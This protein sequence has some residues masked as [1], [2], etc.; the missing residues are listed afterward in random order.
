MWSKS[1]VYFVAYLLIWVP[2]GE[3][4][5]LDVDHQTAKERGITFY[6]QYKARTATTFLNTAAESGD[7]EAQ[8]FL[9]E[10]LRQNNRFM[11]PEAQQWLEAAADQGHV[12]SMIRLVRSGSNLC[13]I[14]GTCPQSSRSPEEWY[15]H[16]YDALL[17]LAEQGNAEAMFQMYKLTQDAEWRARAAEAGHSEAQ[18][19]HAAFIEEG[20][21]FFWWPG[22]RQKAVETWFKASAEGGYPLGMMRYA[23]ILADNADEAGYRYWMNKAAK[24]GY[25]RAVYALAALSGHEPEEYGVELDL[26]K[27]YGLLHL[28]LELDGGGSTGSVAKSTLPDIEKK[29]APEQIERALEFAEEW[30][31]AHPPLSYFPHILYELDN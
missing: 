1:V 4:A 6:N 13:S 28:L 27:S 15:Q 19:W 5:P 10:A 26:V 21:A 14:T 31:A 25:A 22:S 17:P 20:A 2:S 29:M 12:Y 24:T 30:K 7:P 9:G 11:T 16:A 23:G 3:T 18:Y 8:F